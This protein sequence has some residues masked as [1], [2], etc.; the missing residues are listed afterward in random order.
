MTLLN[1][2]IEQIKTAEVANVQVAREAHIQLDT[3]LRSGRF[4][5][6]DQKINARVSTAALISSDLSD[7]RW[8]AG[9]NFL[10]GIR[11]EILAANPTA[12]MEEWEKMDYLKKQQKAEDDQFDNSPCPPEE[13]AALEG[14]GDAEEIMDR[15]VALAGGDVEKL[16][17]V[18][19]AKDKMTSKWRRK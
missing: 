9:M 17:D 8:T 16:A 13:M 11:E 6:P 19:E 14:V 10:A 2:Y 18:L 4:T 12:F 15:A 1:T 7:R 5:T 3:V